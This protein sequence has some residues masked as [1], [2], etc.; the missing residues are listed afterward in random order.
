MSNGGGF[1]PLVVFES[2]ESGGAMAFE[3][4]SHINIFASSGYQY[5]VGQLVSLTD[6]QLLASVP[7]ADLMAENHAKESV[8]TLKRDTIITKPP[9]LKD[10]PQGFSPDFDTSEFG[11]PL[12]TPPLPSAPLPPTPPPSSAV[13]TPS[14]R[15]PLF[16]P[17]STPYPKPPELPLEVRSLKFSL[18]D[19]ILHAEER[20]TINQE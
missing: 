9:T 17:P 7:I 20:A 4:P 3:L 8:L 1:D 11:D 2:L 14:Y 15:S 10:L 18:D 5:E 16:T 19:P 13:S 12:S 6:V